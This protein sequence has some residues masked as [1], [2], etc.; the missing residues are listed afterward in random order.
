MNEKL[1]NVYQHLLKTENR[2]QQ[3]IDDGLWVVEKHYIMFEILHKLHPMQIRGP[4]NCDIKPNF[5]STFFSCP[6]NYY[7][8]NKSPDLFAEILRGFDVWL[9]PKRG[10][11]MLSCHKAW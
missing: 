9:T 8:D 5:L 4:E 11:R 2:K 10:Q 1:G 3:N 6:R 7:K